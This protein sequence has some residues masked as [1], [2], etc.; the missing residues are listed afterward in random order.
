M[1]EERF[2]KVVKFDK[3]SGGMFV[4][5]IPYLFF[6]LLMVF[7][8]LIKNYLLRISLEIIIFVSCLST[9]IVL[10]YELREVYWRRLK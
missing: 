2:E 7:I 5:I 9:A 1:K 8:S 6:M 3:E 10:Y 4:G